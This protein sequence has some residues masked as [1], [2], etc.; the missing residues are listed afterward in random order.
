MDE[1]IKCNYYNNNNINELCNN[2]G[3]INIGQ[4]YRIE[5]KLCIR[6]KKVIKFYILKDLLI[7]II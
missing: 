4:Y 5:N 7:S 1:N 6:K 2:F 3:N